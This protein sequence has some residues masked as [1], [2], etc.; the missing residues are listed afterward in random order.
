MKFEMH[1]VPAY[2]LAGAAAFAFGRMA[3]SSSF[4]RG[5]TSTLMTVPSFEA[6]AAPASTLLSQRRRHPTTN[7]VTRPLPIL[8]HETSCTLAAFSIASMASIMQTKPFVSIMPN[9]S[10][11]FA[12]SS[13][14]QPESASILKQSGKKRLPQSLRFVVFGFQFSVF[15]NRSGSLSEN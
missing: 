6:A 12:I 1:R 5:M 9:A 7:A 11:D 4:G 8:S 14:L 2:F 13:L 10:V 15:R 3:V